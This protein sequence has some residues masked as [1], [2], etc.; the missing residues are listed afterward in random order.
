M[1]KE[2]HYHLTKQQLD[3]YNIISLTIAGHLKI[4]EAADQLE[5]RERQ[6]IRLKQVVMEHGVD[7]LIHKNT[8][9][10]PAHALD[11]SLK[12]SIVDLKLSDPYRQANFNHFKELLEASGVTVSYSALHDLL[13]KAGIKSPK[14]QRKPKK[15]Q[16][17]KRMSQSGLLVQIDATP[18][19]W[20]GDGQMYALHGAIDDA[21]GQVLG[22]YLCKNECLH[23]YLEM[24]RQMLLSHGVPI[25]LYSDKHTIFRSPKTGKLSIEEQLAGK[26][27]NQTQFSRAMQ[28]LGISIIYAR[29]AQAKGRVERL[30]ETLQSRLPVEFKLEGIADPEAANEFLHGYVLRFNDRFAV[31]PEDSTTAFRELSETVNLD[32]VLCVKHERIIDSASVFSFHNRYF[33]VVSGAGAATLP[34]KTRV[35]V[36]ISPMFGLKAECNGTV[37]DVLPFVKSRRISA[38][39]ESGKKK[40]AHRPPADHYWR[41]GIPKVR[42][43]FFESNQEILEILL[44]IFFQREA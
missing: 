25:S 2:V 16:R 20:F 24:S 5:L 3:R 14:K 9:R 44:K 10:T 6:V 15:H 32:H 28:E 23:G 41:T 33:Q 42:V 40:A 27:V 31:E 34:A 26:A 13:S 36:L 30:W 43:D 29:T 37:Y 1:K 17:R 12:K 39:K 4:K 8:N 7:F 19:D 11:A 21:T 22:L 18:F 38:K 35:K